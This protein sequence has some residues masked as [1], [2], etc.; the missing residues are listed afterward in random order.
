MIRSTLAAGLAALVAAAGPVVTHREFVAVHNGMT[1]HHVEADIFAGLTGHSL[2]SYKAADGTHHRIRRY[3][4]ARPHWYVVLDYRLNRRHLRVTFKTH[5]HYTTDG[6]SCH[7]GSP[8]GRDA[9]I[10]PA[11]RLTSRLMDHHHTAVASDRD[12]AANVRAAAARA[13]VRQT[14][15]AD[16]LGLDKRAVARR[17]AGDVPFTALQLDRVAGLLGV[18]LEA[19]IDPA[20]IEG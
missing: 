5:C 9:G 4:T 12:V 20:R 15:V 16:A 3:R 11:Q 7:P 17:F 6:I 1:R 18:Q 13:R 14:T 19:L 8:D 10:R 2:G